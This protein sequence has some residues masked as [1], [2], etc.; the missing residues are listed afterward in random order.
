[1]LPAASQFF[2]S[3]ELEALL[4]THLHHKT[5]SRLTRTSRYMRV[6]FAPHLYREL[7]IGYRPGR[8]NP[9]TSPVATMAL[10]KNADHVRELAI[11]VLSLVYYMN[12]LVVFND[13]QARSTGR[14]ISQPRWV[15]LPDPRSCLVLPILPITLLTMLTIHIWY[16]ATT[17][18]CPYFLPS[19]ANPKATLTQVS[20][21]MLLN[22][23]LQELEISGLIFKDEL[24]GS[25]FCYV[26]SRLAALRKL[27]LMA[28]F[29]EGH[30]QKPIS[31][32]TT[33]VLFCPLRLQ[34]LKLTIFPKNFS[35]DQDLLKEYREVPP[36]F[37]HS[38][39][40]R[41][42]MEDVP[43]ELP[44][45][46]P[47]AQLKLLHL[48]M[49]QHGISELDFWAIAERCPN[50][51]ILHKPVLYGVKDVVS[52][53]D[54]AAKVVLEECEALESLR[55]F[56]KGERGELCVE[57]QDAIELPWV[58]TDLIELVLTIGIPDTPLHH[59]EGSDPYYDR[60]APVVLSE[61]ERHQFGQLERLYERIGSL[62]QLRILNLRVFYFD[63]TGVRAPSK[64][65]RRNSFPGLLS[66]GDVASGRPGYLRQLAGL[67]KLRKLE[68]SVSADTAETWVTI[69][70]SE[71]VWMKVNWCELEFAAL[72]RSRDRMRKPF[73]WLE[74]QRKAEQ[75][76]LVKSIS[77]ARG[78]SLPSLSLIM[79]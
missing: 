12:G 6:R 72:F 78:A 66:L 76:R 59:H 42:G 5:L 47:L 17:G 79:A 20:W 22:S 73:R 60:A 77:S 28:Y 75:A 33:I 50:I 52:F 40:Q 30:Q 14:S 63:P 29:W 25:V 45:D 43:F 4:A 26:I 7:I 44:S 9:L 71:A 16:D 58:C 54:N 3:L 62:T 68:G 11:D 67:K 18:T 19:V 51:R 74:E 34:E 57:L 10:S 21:M 13:L 49:V 8:S 36:G 61:A 31:L 24:D 32:C 39:E 23:N 64:F 56:W 15:A 53:A 46:R 35:Q 38:W 48:Q 69:G 2:A 37:L 70:K 27:E 65:Y 55:V 41:E 1:M